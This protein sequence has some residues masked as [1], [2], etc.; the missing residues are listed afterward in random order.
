M[1]VAAMQESGIGTVSSGG[2]TH[3]HSTREGGLKPAIKK[4]TTFSL[5][6]PDLTMDLIDN[7]W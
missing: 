3:A 1:Q 5:E 7:E 2:V 4:H 6:R